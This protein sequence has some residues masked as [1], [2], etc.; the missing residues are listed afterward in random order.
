MDDRD[1]RGR[2]VDKL[3][4]GTLQG[5]EKDGQLVFPEEGWYPDDEL[6]VLPKQ[7]YA[8]IHRGF[9]P[10]C[11]SRI[12]YDEVTQAVCIGCG[13]VVGGP[14]TVADKETTNRFTE[15]DGSK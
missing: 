3:R 11:D 15:D 14:E 12:E 2:R 13:L 10:L 1:V 9:C 4:R 8:R 6:W 7:R 5:V